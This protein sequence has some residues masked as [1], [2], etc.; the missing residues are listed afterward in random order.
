V[1]KQSSRRCKGYMPFGLASCR[2]A[3]RAPQP[4]LLPVVAGSRVTLWVALAAGSRHRRHLGGASMR[5][6]NRRTSSIVVAPL[7]GGAARRAS[8]GG[9]TSRAGR[10]A[11][12][13][14]G[15]SRSASETRPARSEAPQGARKVG[16]LAP[17]KR[18]RR[19]P[20]TRQLGGL[21][22]TKKIKGQFG[23]TLF[24]RFGSYRLKAPPAA[25][26]LPIK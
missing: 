20:D 12:L 13:R 5:R 7:M 21:S 8:G 14:P 15:R 24:G 18:E 22:Q 26:H 6:C 3:H 4:Q 2:A 23:R 16:V 1:R 11:A 10:A 9:R 25:T 17:A 19:P